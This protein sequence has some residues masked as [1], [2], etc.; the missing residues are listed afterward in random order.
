MGTKVNVSSFRPDTTQHSLH[1]LLLPLGKVDLQCVHPL[2]EARQAVDIGM[3]LRSQLPCP[4]A[5]HLTSTDPLKP[6]LDEE[7]GI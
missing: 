3:Q 2:L 5:R 4:Q 1:V 7:R 6:Q